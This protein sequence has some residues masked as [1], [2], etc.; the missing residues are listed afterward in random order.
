MFYTK[1][2]LQHLKG[3]DIIYIYDIYYR[4][5]INGI[6][7]EGWSQLA[8]QMKAHI[9]K[10]GGFKQ[11]NVQMGVISNSG[12]GKVDLQQFLT[13]FEESTV[14]AKVYIYIIL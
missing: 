7:E 9:S 11:F 10:Q 2:E 14:N 6:S 13:I 5:D 1:L 12:D 4:I 8:D 3:I